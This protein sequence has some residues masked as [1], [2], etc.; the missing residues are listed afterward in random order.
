MRMPVPT[1]A[2]KILDVRIVSLYETTSVNGMP[3]DALV[4]ARI[5]EEKPSVQFGVI[6]SAAPPDWDKYGIPILW[7]DDR[8][9]NIG[10]W[11]GMV[12]GS[13]DRFC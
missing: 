10:R 4:E 8:R 6:F 2:C 13:N 3:L 7:I 5:T 1:K 12:Q 9:I 11:K